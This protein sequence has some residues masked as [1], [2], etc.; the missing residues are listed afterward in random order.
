MH[1]V[2]AISL[3][4]LSFTGA[5]DTVDLNGSQVKALRLRPDQIAPTTH[6]LTKAVKYWD[7]LFPG[8]ACVYQITWFQYC[9]VPHEGLYSP[10]TDCP[11]FNPEGPETGI[12]WRP[13]TILDSI[14]TPMI[15]RDVSPDSSC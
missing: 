10:V 1:A 2:R 14:I 13:S 15:M 7:C 5:V 3:D 12:S 8:D 9:I 6:T 4:V 11:Y